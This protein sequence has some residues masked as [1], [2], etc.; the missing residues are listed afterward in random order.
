MN[1]SIFFKRLFFC[2][3]LYNILWGTIIVLQPNLFFQIFDLPPLNYP[4]IM[5]GVGMFVAVYGYGYWVVS[6]DLKQYPQLVIIGLMGKTL[7]PIGWSYHVYLGSIPAV[8]L[9]TNFFNDLIWIPF[10]IWYL[11]WHR[12]EYPS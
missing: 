12:T 6:K 9:W 10:F 7:G 8:T 3:A 5:S 11:V 4:F 2:A 1:K